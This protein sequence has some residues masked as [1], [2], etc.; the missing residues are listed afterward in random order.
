MGSSP[1]EGLKGPANQ[2]VVLPVKAASDPSRLKGRGRAPRPVAG[3]HGPQ[4]TRSRHHT[5]GC[6][7][8]LSPGS[9]GYFKYL[10]P[11]RP[12][13][14]RRGR[15][16]HSF[17]ALRKYGS[18]QRA[19][20]DVFAPASLC[21]RLES[22][23]RGTTGR[24]LMA[25]PSDPRDVNPMPVARSETVATRKKAGHALQRSGEQ[26]PDERTEDAGY[27]GAAVRRQP[28]QTTRGA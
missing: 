20:G 21:R 7:S 27:S 3:L 4:H 22:V 8:V 23:H 15:P 2:D 28:G 5:V 16:R 12:R 1:T 9:S 25:M 18:A 10:P 11:C 14:N 17:T 13:D 19:G 24:W 6:A 26:K